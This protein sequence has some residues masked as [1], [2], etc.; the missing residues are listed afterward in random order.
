MSCPSTYFAPIKSF[1]YI[2]QSFLLQLKFC[3]SVFFNPSFT[4]TPSWILI[5]LILL[6]THILCCPGRKIACLT[7][8]ATKGRILAYSKPT[9]NSSYL[10]FMKCLH[11]GHLKKYVKGKPVHPK[12]RK[13]NRHIGR[14][15]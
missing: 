3:F 8:R 7:R 11:R 9:W 10:I 2:Y 15:Y 13:A 4:H 14:I 1:H 6:S 5:A 12:K